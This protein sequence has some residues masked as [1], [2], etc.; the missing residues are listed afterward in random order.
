MDALLVAFLVSSTAVLSVVL[1]VLGAY[2]AITGL[3]A[4]VNPARPAQ[5]LR[6]LVP[7]Q[8]QATGD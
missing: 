2:Y 1:G 8:S 3:L 5:F 4:A 6:A 7:H